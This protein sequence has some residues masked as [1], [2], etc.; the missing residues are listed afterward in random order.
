MELFFI[1]YLLLQIVYSSGVKT[2]KKPPLVGYA[3]LPRLLP[4][5]IIVGRPSFFKEGI[6]LLLS[7][8]VETGW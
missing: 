5:F 8:F 4:Y 3:R 2:I 6:K 1:R 7:N